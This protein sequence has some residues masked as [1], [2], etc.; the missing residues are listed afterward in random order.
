MFCEPDKE[1][2]ERVRKKG[3]EDWE[4]PPCVV[5]SLRVPRDARRSR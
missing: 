1:W 2:G 4:R 3:R 5:Q